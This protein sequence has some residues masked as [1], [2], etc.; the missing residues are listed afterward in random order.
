MSKLLCGRKEILLNI[1]QYQVSYS[2]EFLY[3]CIHAYHHSLKHA[4]RG[5]KIQVKVREVMPF[6]QIS[7]VEKY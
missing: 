7:A 6:N 2:K 4:F 3:M 1:V 5:N